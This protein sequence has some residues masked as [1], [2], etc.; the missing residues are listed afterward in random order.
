M[1]YVHVYVCVPVYVCD[2]MYRYVSKYSPLT[3]QLVLVSRPFIHLPLLQNSM[4]G[5]SAL[6]VPTFS[7]LI[8]T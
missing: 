4:K 1:I 2:P 6:G 8:L 5:L 7:S 3:P